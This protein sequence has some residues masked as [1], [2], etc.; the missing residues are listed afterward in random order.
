MNTAKTAPEA[1]RYIIEGTVIDHIPPGKALSIVRLLNLE[2]HHESITI[3]IH[4]P[5]TVYGKKD[6]IKIE[7]RKLTPEEASQIALFAPYATISII[8]NSKVI[9]KFQVTL[10]PSL[11]KCMP[12][13]NSKCIT[14]Q[15]D[16]DTSFHLTSRT[17]YIEILCKYCRKSFTQEDISTLK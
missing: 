10:P 12:C 11:H 6:L 15:E 13:P 2:K 1:I 4:L 7:K 17:D 3:G 9:D 14:N 16:I 5:S 8:S